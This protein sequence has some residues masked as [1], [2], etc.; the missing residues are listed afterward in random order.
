V[1]GDQPET[2]SQLKR[3]KKL[4]REWDS[5]KDETNFPDE[6]SR[7]ATMNEGVTRTAEHDEEVVP[8]MPATST[9]SRASSL[10]RKLEEMTPAKGTSQFSDFSEKATATC[11]EADTIEELRS[12]LLKS[13]GVT[14]M[15]HPFSKHT[16][17]ANSHPADE[18][19]PNHRFSHGCP[20]GSSPR[21]TKS[22]LVS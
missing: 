15:E 18:K 7:T 12:A 20:T 4:F 8:T 13:L 17:Q 2:E 21:Q 16:T 5:V 22:P 3:L 10:E 1:N 11:T 14:A 6:G 9:S 19:P